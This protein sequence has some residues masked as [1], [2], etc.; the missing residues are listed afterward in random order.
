MLEELR[1]MK[2]QL[3]QTKKTIENT[4]FSEMENLDIYGTKD[5]I[6]IEK[7]REVFLEILVL[8]TDL[9]KFFTSIQCKAVDQRIKTENHRDSL[10]QKALQKEE[11]FFYFNL[12]FIY[13]SNF[14]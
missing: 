10:K 8:S 5:L 7:S 6:E 9:K 1:Q 3:E 12:I 14:L 13:L 4:K 2:N 11:P